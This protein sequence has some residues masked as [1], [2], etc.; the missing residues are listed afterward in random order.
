M[1]L[2]DVYFKLSTQHPL[3]LKEFSLFHIFPS[4]SFIFTIIINKSL[5]YWFYIFIQV[6]NN[7]TGSCSESKVTHGLLLSAALNSDKNNLTGTAKTARISIAIQ[8]EIRVSSGALHCY[9]YH[10]GQ[11]K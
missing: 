3:C 11:A 1:K 8:E 7:E 10:F 5:V 6:V 4:G 2:T 9:L